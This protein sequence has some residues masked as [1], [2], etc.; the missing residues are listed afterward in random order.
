MFLSQD[1]KLST[2]STV[3]IAYTLV[4]NRALLT[5]NFLTPELLFTTLEQMGDWV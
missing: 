1:R 4:M 3:S 2:A 5:L